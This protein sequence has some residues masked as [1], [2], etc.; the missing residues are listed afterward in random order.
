MQ[1]DNERF[2]TWM[3]VAVIPTS[4][5]ALTLGCKQHKHYRLLILGIT[6]LS[7]LCFAVLGGSLI[8]ESGE[9]LLTVLGSIF[10]ASGH[11]WNYRLC[12]KSTECSCP[13]H[14]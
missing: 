14:A 3:L 9:K 13:E 2:H 7:L 1:L 12:Q 8:G 10:V 6:G 4:I 5:V 11:I